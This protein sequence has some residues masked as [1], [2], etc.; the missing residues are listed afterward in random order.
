MPRKFIRRYLPDHAKVREHKHLRLFGRL[1]HDPNLLHLNRTS[2]SG[3]FSVGLFWTFV[4]IP[5]QMVTAAASAIWLR[6]NLPIS[7]ALVWISNPLTMPALF[8]FCYRVGM[9]ILGRPPREG[10]QFEAS[11]Q[12][13]FSEVGTIWFPMLIG[14]I[15]VGSL[16]ALF[17]NLVIRGLWRLHLIRYLQQRR[18]RRHLRQM[19]QRDRES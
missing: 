9:W 13:L 5:F 18:L 3:A 17:A 12:W 6:V 2:V 11:I 1:L 4:P 8:Y 10:I 14:G 7:V 15:V 19:E 16:A